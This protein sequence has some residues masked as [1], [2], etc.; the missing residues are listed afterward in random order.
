[1]ECTISDEIDFHHP[2]SQMMIKR[3]VVYNDGRMR[4]PWEHYIHIRLYSLHELLAMFREA[5][6]RILE[7]S[8]DYSYEGY[9]LGTTSRRIMI[10]GEKII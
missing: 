9:F 6:F 10:L 8:G 1:M 4:M 5:G 2:K 7:V 3:T